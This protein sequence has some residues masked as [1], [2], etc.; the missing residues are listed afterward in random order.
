M[1]GCQL[2]H[3]LGREQ[4]LYARPQTSAAYVLPEAGPP[5]ATAGGAMHVVSSNIQPSQAM[6]PRRDARLGPYDHEQIVGRFEGSWQAVLNCVPAAALTSR[7]DAHHLLM[8]FFGAHTFNSGVSTLYSLSN[9]GLCRP[10]SLLR[11]ANRSQAVYSEALRLAAVNQFTLAADGENAPTMTFDGIF[12]EWVG[13]GRAEVDETGATQT[14]IDVLATTIDNLMVGQISGTYGS[15][16]QIG[17]NTNGGAGYH[18]TNVDRTN[19][20][21]T[22]DTGVTV[23]DGDAIIPYAPT[24]T[25]SSAPMIGFT[26]GGLDVD[27]V[28]MPIK[29][30]SV[31]GNRNLTALN[32]VFG[33]ASY[34]DAVADFADLM[35]EF[36]LDARSDMT[37]ELAKS[38]Y[39]DERDVQL[40]LGTGAGRT[41][42]V[43]MPR[44]QPDHSAI[45]LNQIGE[46]TVSGRLLNTTEGAANALSITMT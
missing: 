34:E 29:S 36:T 21:I 6:I 20:D 22:V 44:W 40:V 38:A 43:D 8:G 32:N 27:A 39:H 31:T 42:T 17:A 13:T 24:P 46:I 1:S 26:V 4:V 5:T 15:R 12:A 37:V 33:T 9:S 25:L 3:V 35:F 2:G 28:D 7:P 30:I 45:A 23:T 14:E 10:F 16:V 19:D 18:V 41:W 11:L